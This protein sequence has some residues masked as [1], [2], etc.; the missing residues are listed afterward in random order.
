[1]TALP[2]LSALPSLQVV[3]LEGCDKLKEL[4]KLPEGVEWDECHK[5]SHFQKES[6]EDEE[7]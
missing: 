7:P 4:P 2:D 5:P 6:P 1:V 3:K